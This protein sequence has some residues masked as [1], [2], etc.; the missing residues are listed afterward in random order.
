M[1]QELWLSRDDTRLAHY[2]LGMENPEIDPQGT[3]GDFVVCFTPEEFHK[4]FPGNSLRKGRK[5]RIKRILIEL[6]D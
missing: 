5:R 2:N 1:E 3:Y 6:E 4:M